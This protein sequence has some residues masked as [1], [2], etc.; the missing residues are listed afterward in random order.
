MEV[1]ENLAEVS[2]Y[3]RIIKKKNN[4]SAAELKKIDRLLG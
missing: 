2:M 1:L 4:L 3:A